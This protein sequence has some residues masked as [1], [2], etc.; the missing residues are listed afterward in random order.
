MWELISEHSSA[1]ISAESWRTKYTPLD[2]EY[3]LGIFFGSYESRG[4]ISSQFLSKGACEITIIVYFKEIDTKGLRCTYDKKLFRQVSICSKT[5]PN[6]IENESISDIDKILRKIIEIIPH[7]YFS[8][9]KKWFIDTSVSPKPYYL[10]LLGYLHKRIESP[11]ITLFNATGHYEQI[12]APEE[13]FSFTEGFEQY[14]WIPWIWGRVD[15]KLPWTY[16]FLL[17]FEGDRSYGTYDRF[18]PK[19]VKAMI[20]RPGYRPDYP[21]RAIDNNRQF[22]EESCPE[23]VFA[24]AAD[25]VEAWE[26]IESN[27]HNDRK[28]SNLCIVPLGPKPHAIGGALSALTDG[29]PAVLYLM[30]KSHKVRDVPRGDYIWRYEISL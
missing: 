1:G 10:G 22:L 13:A 25:A 4:L 27:I 3:N 2:V 20:S 14:V 24:D 6:K 23:I 17:G 18:E 8:K 16:F 5:E 12:V 19:Y 29:K 28:K 15:P 26:K 11:R 21:E 7:S 9:D 30:P